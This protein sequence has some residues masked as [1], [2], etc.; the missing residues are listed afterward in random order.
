MKNVEKI[1]CPLV[2]LSGYQKVSFRNV[3]SVPSA[4]ANLIW[5]HIRLSVTHLLVLWTTEERQQVFNHHKLRIILISISAEMEN[6]SQFL[7]REDF[8]S[9]RE[10]SREFKITLVICSCFKEKMVNVILQRIIWQ[11]NY[12]T[13]MEI[14]YREHRK[15][16]S[17]H[18]NKMLPSTSMSVNQRLY[19]LI[20][21]FLPGT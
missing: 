13:E 17:H 19:Q 20:F 6:R 15:T 11:S 1:G 18:E 2:F 9:F 7:Y 10:Q 3:C 12:V 16:Q 14:H 5:H 8:R 21:S 4:E